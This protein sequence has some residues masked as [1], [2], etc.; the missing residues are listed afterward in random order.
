MPQSFARASCL[1]LLVVA[2]LHVG[3]SDSNPESVAPGADVS[4]DTAQADADANADAEAADSG[5]TETGLVD[6][7]IDTEDSGPSW[8][9]A[10]FGA[11]DVDLESVAGTQVRELT[12]LVPGLE[13]E[14]TLELR[15]WYATDDEEGEGA[16]FA[17][18]IFSD[19]FAW[20]DASILAPPEGEQAPMLVFSHGGRGFA[21]QIS[22][23]ARQFVR[24]GWV[25]VAP[26]HPGH[27]ILDTD[28][29]GFSFTAV[30]G[31]DVIEAIDHMEELPV[32]HPLSGR[33]DTSRVLA[34]GHSFGGQNAWLLGG[35]PLN[36]AEIRERC[37]TRCSAEE[38]AIFEAFGPDDR[39][40]AGISL[41]N[42]IDTNLVLDESFASNPT[43]MLHIS[44]TEGNDATELFAR[45]AAANLTWVS[46]LGGCHESST[47]TLACPTLP[48]EES[49]RATAVYAVAFAARHVLESTD[50]EVAEILNG[51]SEVS[52][53]AVL[54]LSP[55]VP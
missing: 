52:S 22:R 25:V 13:E 7:A 44:G 17:L 10:N 37:E 9:P 15:L 31:F 12:Y 48:L 43:P 14:R 28:E 46:L 24:N 55:G 50:S 42:L 23:V 35:L 4:D 45:A 27:T 16:Y 40:V 51:S 39:V 36:M 38:L 19:E 2:T 6:I 47:G 54:M 3:C 18:P 29:P 32:D 53:S 21:G 30:R 20:T 5:D 1:R 11:P 34:M 8:V 41:D 26:T 33:V 49:L